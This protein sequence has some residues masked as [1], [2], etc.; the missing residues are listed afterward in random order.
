MPKGQKAR[1]LMFLQKF[2]SITPYDA[3]K[4][5]GI[6]RLSAIIF[7]LRNDE[8]NPMPIATKMERSINRFGEPVRYARYVMLEESE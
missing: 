5:F 6:M 2:G 8:K 7:K 3:D 1:V 4:E